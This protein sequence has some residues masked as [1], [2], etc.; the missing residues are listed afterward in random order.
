M[1]TNKKLKKSLNFQTYLKDQLKNPKLKA[2]Y[3]EAGKKLEV[4]YQVVQLRKRYGVSQLQ[5]AR[6]IGTT[7][8]NVARIEAGQQNFTTDTL[9]KI[10]KAFKVD[11]KIEFV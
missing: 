1:N 8:S 10:A 9:Q 7:Q 5:L 2:H 4:A 11:L 6:K 3:D